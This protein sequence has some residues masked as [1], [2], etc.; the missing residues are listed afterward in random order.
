MRELVHGHDVRVLELPG[1]LRLGDEAVAVERL[2][3][4]LLV[5][6]LERDVAEQVAIGGRMNVPHAAAPELRIERRCSGVGMPSRS[7]SS[8]GD[9]LSPATGMDSIT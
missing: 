3:R 8:G 4:E 2:A 7:E 6:A 9:L 5:E 1:H